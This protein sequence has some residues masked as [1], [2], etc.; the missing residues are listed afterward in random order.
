[1]EKGN[2]G[3]KRTKVVQKKIGSG[4]DQ[5]NKDGRKKMRNGETKQVKGKQLPAWTEKQKKSGKA[6]EQKKKPRV[7]L[8]RV[9]KSN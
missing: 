4:S 3:A 9:K 2:R 5:K 8:P 6:G 7:A 1:V